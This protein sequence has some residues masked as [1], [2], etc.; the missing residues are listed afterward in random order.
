MTELY[1]EPITFENN[2]QKLTGLAHIPSQSKPPVIVM[3]HGWTGNMH[4][5]GLFVRCA[6]SLC[7]EGFLVFRFDY[8]GS[9]HSEGDFSKITVK[10]EV[11]DFRMALKT[12]SKLDCDI[13]RLGV[14]GYSLGGLVAIKGA[15]TLANALV[16]WAPVSNPVEE[17]KKILGPRKVSMLE[18]KGYTWYLKDPSPYRKKLRYKVGLPFWREIQSIHPLVDAKRINCPIRV[19]HGTEDESVDFRHSI[20]LMKNISS[21][22]DLKLI[23]NANHF[24]DSPD[25]EKQLIDLTVKWFK[26]WI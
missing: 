3:C 17:F 11:S 2:G 20:D 6:Q 10:E 4:S 7:E 8:R 25:H 24:F 19:I 9:E 21:K 22:N 5:H 26:K 18:K 23:E 12:V 15:K 1:I 13:S 14:L 16:L